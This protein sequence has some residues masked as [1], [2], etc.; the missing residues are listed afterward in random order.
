MRHSNLWDA[1]SASTAWRAHWIRMWSILINCGLVLNES[2]S[3][4]AQEIWP[5]RT[6]SA[7]RSVPENLSIAVQKHLVQGAHEQEIRSSMK[8]W[9]LL[10]KNLYALHMQLVCSLP[11]WIPEHYC[12]GIRS[13]SARCHWRRA[14]LNEVLSITAQEW[15]HSN[16]AYR[17]AQSRGL[18]ELAVVTH[19]NN[20]HLR[21]KHI[22]VVILYGASATTLHF[23]RFSSRISRISMTHSLVFKQHFHMW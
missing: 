23:H 5:R 15:P 19:L 10:S 17:L 22:W 6:Q 2:L 7:R 11:Q 18:R 14:V 8:A 13:L 12:S 16:S 9:T 4:N 1:S 20:H 21:C 3:N